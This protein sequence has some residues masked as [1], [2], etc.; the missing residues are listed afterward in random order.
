MTPTWDGEYSSRLHRAWMCV[1]CLHPRRD[2]FN[3][4]F[5]SSL[6]FLFV[7]AEDWNKWGIPHTHTSHKPFL[8]WNRYKRNICLIMREV[9]CSFVIIPRWKQ[10]SSNCVESL[11]IVLVFQTTKLLL[12]LLLLLFPAYVWGFWKSPSVQLSCRNVW[13]DKQ[14]PRPLLCDALRL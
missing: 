11:N 7:P 5:P 8:A 2:V 9:P 13:T 1:L 6:S 10:F 4:T 12:F 3:L 14:S